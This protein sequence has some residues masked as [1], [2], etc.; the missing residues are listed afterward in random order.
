MRT[1][2][3]ERT[4]AD[5]SLGVLRYMIVI[6]PTLGFGVLGMVILAVTGIAAARRRVQ[7]RR[8]IRVAGVIASYRESLSSDGPSVH[9]PAIRGTRPQGPAVVNPPAALP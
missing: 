7:H 5:E 2:S 3:L 8:A 6:V 9:Y 4:T 1:Y